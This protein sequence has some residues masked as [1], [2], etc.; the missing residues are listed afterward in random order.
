MSDVF[1]SYSRADTAFVR[2]LTGALE[3][4]GKVAWVDVS[5]IRDGEVFPAA[6]RR[7]IETSDG[8]VFVISPGS[9]TSAYCEQEVAHALELNKRVVPLLLRS[10]PDD[11]VPEAIRERQWIP[12]DDGAQFADGVGRL[13]EALDTDL[14]WTRAHTRW[15]LKALEWDHE[16]RDRS[17]LLRGAELAAAE[18][19]LAGAPGKQPE[20]TALQRE[21]VHR[22][23]LAAGRRMRT[24]VAA[25][26]IALVA[27]IALGLIALG[28]RNDAR[29][30]GAAAR[31]R[32]LAALSAGQ[33]ASDPELSVLLGREAVRTDATP[34]ALFA[35]REALDASALRRTLR[36]RKPVD[37]VTYGPDGRM[38]A[39]VNQDNIVTLWNA[40]TGAALRRIST[41]T[42]PMRVAFTPDGTSVVVPRDTGGGAVYGVAS[43]RLQRTFRESEHLHDARFSANGRLLVTAGHGVVEVLDGRTLSLRRAYAVHEVADSAAISPDDKHVAAAT[44]FGLRLWDARTGRMQRFLSMSGGALGLAFSPDGSRLAFGGEHLVRLMDPATG[45]VTRTLARLPGA[46]V[47]SVAFSPDGSRLA[48]SGTDGIARLYDMRTGRATERFAGHRCCV[49]TVAF[50]PDGRL[51]ATSSKDGTVKLWS[52]QGNALAATH[53]DVGAVTGV[54]YLPG[55]H[56]LV[57]AGRGGPAAAWTI[58]SPRPPQPLG[59]AGPARR[60][61]LS[62]DGRTLALAGTGLQTQIVDVASGRIVR[63]LMTS[64]PPR[65]VALDQRARTVAIASDLGAGVFTVAGGA[66]IADLH[67]G[68]TVLAVAFAPRRN[69]LG[70]TT[71]TDAG[72]A[73]LALTPFP[74]GD[75][76]AT[77]SE[78]NPIRVIAFSPD[79]RL[80]VGATDADK[81][82][83]VWDVVRRR[84]VRELFGHTGAVTG[85]AFSPDGSLLATASRDGTVRIWDPRD[86]TELRAIREGAPVTAVAFSPNGRQVATGDGNGAVRVWDACTG[87]R[88]ASALLA[89]RRPTRDFTPIERKTFLDPGGR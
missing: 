16:G 8:F 24:L 73:I 42:T 40:H 50:S 4:R 7:A 38:L 31:S 80:V 85:A 61:A 45:R 22:S 19:W 53:A 25:M 74:R 29:R 64:T 52:T 62:E 41:G 70:L 86:G 9:V 58:G 75:D 32:E 6:L 44:S 54:A 35:L 88:D 1:V 14:D 51:L 46:S 20:P 33:L 39:T 66:H 83:K 68:E 72:D 48:V 26:A 30:Q 78:P 47:L 18:R 89:L 3:A 11:G 28:Q 59:G 36:S 23:R 63:T 15:L 13:I 34:Q 77:F 10:V 60:M 65:A 56:R 49:N 17:F 5:G 82:V 43:G 57:V 67:E 84:K 71:V 79:G 37:A 12:F 2:R 81:T 21:Y 69:V 87:C 55:G 27:S 76:R